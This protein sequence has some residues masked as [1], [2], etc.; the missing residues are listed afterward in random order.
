MKSE[1]YAF[2][3]LIYEILTRGALG[4]PFEARLDQTIDVNHQYEYLREFIQDEQNSPSRREG[5]AVFLITLPNF[6]SKAVGKF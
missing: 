2:G 5:S 6:K 4:H 3:F 1:V